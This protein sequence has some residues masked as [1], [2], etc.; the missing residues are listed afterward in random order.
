MFIFVVYPLSVLQK[1]PKYLDWARGKLELLLSDADFYD[2]FKMTRAEFLKL[3]AWKQS[4]L[5]MDLGIF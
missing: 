4:K 2:A 1:K 5:K 3:P